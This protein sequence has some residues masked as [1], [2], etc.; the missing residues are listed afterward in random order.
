MTR[1]KFYTGV[2][3]Y[4]SNIDFLYKTIDNENYFAEL[5][6]TVGESDIYKKAEYLLS[7]R[8]LASKQLDSTGAILEH[9]YYP[10]SPSNYESSEYGIKDGELFTT[11]LATS[12]VSF[13]G[14]IL[15]VFTPL[16]FNQ[17]W[18]YSYVFNKSAEIGLCKWEAEHSTSLLQCIETPFVVVVIRKAHEFNRKTFADNDNKETGNV[19][20]A[21]ARH[22]SINDSAS[23]M[24]FA[25]KF[26]L[27]P[28][29][30]KEGMEFVFLSRNTA[31]EHPEVVI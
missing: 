22:I 26:Q 12:E 14:E 28:E 1:K 8:N 18:N 3:S 17:N 6:S 23:I 9:L 10:L 29:E 21:V 16:T 11:D 27:V 20:N 2:P 7:I 13:D 24:N 5:L 15:R 31:L 19:I 30:E 4:M 25:S